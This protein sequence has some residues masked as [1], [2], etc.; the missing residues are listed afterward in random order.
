[1]QHY[2][3]V[4]HPDGMYGQIEE[5]IEFPR[6]PDE[7]AT[8]RWYNFTIR[9]DPRLPWLPARVKKQIDNFEMVINSRW[10]TIQDIKLPRW[11]RAM[12]RSLSLW[13]YAFGVYDFPLE[14][15]WAQRLIELRKPRWE[16]I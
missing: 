11:G 15:R 14:L 2:I 3:P 1:M 16:S 10:P 12:L 6:T 4:P 5:K 7:W 9:H 8:E 13:R